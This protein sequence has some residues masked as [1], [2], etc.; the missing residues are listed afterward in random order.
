MP[1]K[2]GKPNI[3]E[4][5]VSVQGPSARTSGES[6]LQD[7][8]VATGLLCSPGVALVAIPARVDPDNFVRRIGS[9]HRLLAG[10]RTVTADALFDAPIKRAAAFRLEDPDR[11]YVGVE[12]MIDRKRW[13]LAG[14]GFGTHE[15][16]MADNADEWDDEAAGMVDDLLKARKRPSRRW[17]DQAEKALANDSGSRRS[18]PFV[19]L[20][21]PDDERSADGAD[22]LPHGDGWSP[23]PIPFEETLPRLGDGSAPPRNPFAFLFKKH[24]K[25]V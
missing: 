1:T 5:Y 18:L 17:F 12:L 7:S 4:L 23:S 16:A 8:H 10:G 19:P 20:P 13:T 25:K 3:S 21:P 22:P 6:I 11:C 24:P 14:S 2:P 9:G 15:L